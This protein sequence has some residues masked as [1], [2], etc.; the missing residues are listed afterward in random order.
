MSQA[1]KIAQRKAQSRIRQLCCLGLGDQLT[2]PTLLG[3]LH[4]YIPSHANCFFWSDDQG[5]VR[6]IYDERPQ[7]LEWLPTYLAE[8]HNRI[9]L[10][11]FCGWQ[12]FL[13][14]GTRA[15]DYDSLLTVDRRHYDN[16]AY[17]HEVMSQL[18]FYWG[19]FMVVREHGRPLG[20]LALHRTE[21]ERR[22]DVQDAQHL[23][24]IM[25][26]IAHAFSTPGNPEHHWIDSDDEGLVITDQQ[27]RL[28]SASA[29]GQHLLALSSSERPWAPAKQGAIPQ[30]PDLLRILCRRLADIRA[31]IQ[32]SKAPNGT[33]Q[34]AWGRFVFRAYWLQTQH[35]TGDTI[36]ISIRRQE[37]MPLKLARHIKRLP[38]S[39]KQAEV[40]LLMATGSSYHQIAERQGMKRNTA[41]SHGREIYS[42]LGVHNREQLVAEILARP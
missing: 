40:C 13:C 7:A 27:G 42:R 37:P 22:F 35:N 8:F 9:E 18:D 15:V 6:D 30:P 10:E 1:G 21:H 24:Q 5:N 26:F 2:I 23:D 32:L 39:T 17:Y 29:G 4:D 3:E 28:I 20:A 25:P 33:I 11:V 36:G 31:G 14:H 19:L 16:H 12:H 41:I 38:L 34:N